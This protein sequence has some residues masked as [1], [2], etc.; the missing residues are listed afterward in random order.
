M[1]KLEFQ[2]TKILLV[3][4]L[5]GT[6]AVCLPVG[7]FA[8]VTGEYIETLSSTP[9]PA[10]TLLIC[11]LV[12]ALA[13]GYQVLYFFSIRYELDDRYVVRASGVLWKKRRSIPLEKI[14]NI[15]V[16][17]GPVE[18]AIGYGKIWIFTPSTGAA[19]PEEKLIGVTDPHAMKQT[20]ID[21]CES[22][23]QHLP[24]GPG[25][26]ASPAEP[27]ETVALLTEIRDSLHNIE[28]C[29]A[30]RPRDGNGA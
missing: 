28:N 22:A 18:R 21:R 12:M 6:C 17:Q 7:I 2:P 23:R 25:Q 20:I 1:Q 15:D 11:L 8:V 14:T 10:A 27:A 24:A 30:Q 4:W 29:L 26:P 19:T 9:A 16:R 5:L 13:G 3:F